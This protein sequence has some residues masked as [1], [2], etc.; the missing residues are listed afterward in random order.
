VPAQGR[1]GE[2][3][4]RG[5]CAHG[6][7]GHAQRAVRRA[8]CAPSSSPHLL[9]S[10]L[11]PCIGAA[12]S[13]PLRTWLPWNLCPSAQAD[14]ERCEPRSQRQPTADRRM[15]RSWAATC[16]EHACSAWATPALTLS[17]W[18]RATRTKTTRCASSHSSSVGPADCARPPPTRAR[19][20][21]CAAETQP[22]PPPRWPS[23]VGG[24][25]PRVWS[26]HRGALWAGVST[27]I[28]TVLGSRESSRSAGRAS[29]RR[30]MTPRAELSWRTLHGAA[31]TWSMCDRPL[32][33][34]RARTGLIRD[35]RA[36]VQL[37]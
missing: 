22:T 14:P 33:D 11:S 10:T 16:D 26:A 1:R 6:T 35:R 24:R 29:A 36:A 7:R 34:R 17:T 31:S 4:G 21:Q 2:A 23:W 18:C 9:P 15:L 19:A 8:L 27:A 25:A 5:A 28:M 30:S 37:C 12:T 13:A 32:R 3:A 20:L